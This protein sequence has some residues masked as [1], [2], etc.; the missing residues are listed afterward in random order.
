MH[1]SPLLYAN[2]NEETLHSNKETDCI[3]N[4]ERRKFCWSKRNYNFFPL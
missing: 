2:L 1:A 4:F 3:D